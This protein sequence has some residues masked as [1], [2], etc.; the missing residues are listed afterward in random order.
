MTHHI[1]SSRAF[2]SGATGLVMAG[3]LFCQAG[4]AVAQSEEASER[5]EF[6]WL[7]QIN[8]ASILIN[9]EEGLLDP[10]LA[11][12]IGNA[13][14]TVLENGEAPDADRPGTVITFEPLLIEEGGVEVTLI[15][16]GR[17]SQDMH[18]TYRAAMLRDGMLDLADQLNATTQ[19][20]VDLAGRHVDTIVPNY[21]NGV[22]AQPNS[23]AHYLLGHAAG[24]DRDAQRIREAYGRIDRSAMGT[25]VLNGTSWPLNRQRMAD[26][27]GFA[28]VV[29][30]AYDASQISSMDE[31]VEV[32][33]IITSI[34]LHTG[35]FVED[36]ITQYAQSR[37][38]ILLEEGGDNTYVSS[39]MP[40]KRNPGILNS[41][42]SDASQAI[43]LAMGPVW[44]THNITPGMSDPKGTDENAAMLDAGVSTLERLDRVLKAL[45]I[46]PDRAL[47]ELNSDWTASQEVADILMRDHGLPFR[48]GHHVAS[49]IVSHARAQGIGPLDFPYAEA[50]QIY[51]ETVAG[52][53]FAQELPMSEAEFRAALD[54][55]AIVANRATSG[56]PQ[57]AEVERMLTEA[58]DRLAAQSDWIAERR[59]RIDS[60]LT[61]LDSD[62]DAMLSK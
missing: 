13:L 18:A 17:S 9:S 3:A 5:D 42:R 44:Q 28:S 39:A 29:D 47:E 25:T 32:G 43:A 6:F 11:P 55:A 15:H 31:P 57:P 30:N 38:W 19:T 1:P 4:M 58:R 54:P 52:T 48:E 40:Q 16:A 27:L 10:E 61:Q 34:A 49:E 26:Y 56:G 59:G 21:T 22:A 62:F 37:P 8:K 50:Q 51:A 46:N 23:Y 35:N 12:S 7:G 2:R 41:T 14:V 24:L 20:L 36:V 45:Q 33:Q 53:E 60:A